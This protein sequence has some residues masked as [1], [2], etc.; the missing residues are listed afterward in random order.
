MRWQV[1]LPDVACRRA[2]LRK[3]IA[4]LRR[5]LCNDG[6][7]ACEAGLDGRSQCV[8]AGCPGDGSC[9]GHGACVG[10]ACVC[11]A[12]HEGVDCALDVRGGASALRP[13]LWAEYYSWT[14]GADSR[15]GD[16]YR[17][18]VFADVAPQVNE[19]WGW[20]APR[21]GLSTD[22][23]AV[24][25]QGLLRP[26]VGGALRVRCRF[27]VDWCTVAVA[28]AVVASGSDGQ[29]ASGSVVP[30][31][32]T[33]GTNYRLKVEMLKNGQYANLVLEW[34]LPGGAGFVPVPAGE[35]RAPRTKCAEP[36]R[37]ELSRELQSEC[38]SPSAAQR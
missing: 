28:G 3:R 36:G 34:F 8:L 29:G 19:M 4:P 9:S 20:G 24:V 31:N 21:P 33:A 32:V 7:C 6:V 27:S 2:R 16:R 5:G 18:R 14:D 30:F 38:R 25:Y 17:E 10:G 15:V 37:T 22:T 12:E 13:G 23:Y 1:R 11:D 35:R 26:F